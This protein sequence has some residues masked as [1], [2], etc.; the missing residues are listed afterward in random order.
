M[1]PK[2]EYASELG[3]VLIGSIVSPKSEN[4]AL[5]KERENGSIK[6]Y[7]KNFVLLKKYKIIAIHATHL[8]LGHLKDTSKQIAVYKDGFSGVQTTKSKSALTE[9]GFKGRYS[10]NGF[11]RV[12]D[13]ITISSD[14]R[15]KILE[16]DLPKIL[17]QA[18]AEP[19]VRDGSLVGFALDQIEKDSIFEKAGLKNGDIVT[20]INGISLQDVTVAIKVLRSIKDE[21]EINFEL[22]RNQKSIPVSIQVK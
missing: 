2:I 3:L 8:I 9:T 18:S 7:K 4:V 6:A 11:E 5:I 19:I 17:M 21:P 16:K 1:Q 13:K 14:Y 15:Q 12:D 22:E 10:E 20:S